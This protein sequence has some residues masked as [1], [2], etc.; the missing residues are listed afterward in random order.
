MFNKREFKGKEILGKL[1]Y[2][3]L[4]PKEAIVNIDIQ[5]SRANFDEMMQER[6]RKSAIIFTIDTS[7]SMAGMLI[8]S[9]KKAAK[10]FAAKYFS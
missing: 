8:D 3:I 6:K 5:L 7:G 2:K 4:N 9:V 10:T 1:S